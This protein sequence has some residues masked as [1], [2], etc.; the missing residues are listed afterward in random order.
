MH[1]RHAREHQIEAESRFELRV[2]VTDLKVERLQNFRGSLRVLATRRTRLLL[3]SHANAGSDADAYALVPYGMTLA[4]ATDVRFVPISGEIV[5]SRTRHTIV[6]GV[7]LL[8]LAATGGC[9]RAE[10]RQF[11]GDTIRSGWVSAARPSTLR[12]PTAQR[13]F[14]RIASE[15]G[16]FE[17][18][19]SRIAIARGGSPAVR[20][21]AEATLRDRVSVD[22]DLQQ[23]A[24]SVGVQLPSQLNATMQARLAVLATL[25]GSDFDRAYARNVG[26]MA[27]EEALLAFERAA[28]EEGERIER[29]AASQLPTLRKHLEWARQL[30]AEL[31]RTS[32]A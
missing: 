12:P 6:A 21:F 2:N 30:A 22:T 1:P 27:Q 23:L 14:L 9:D 5:R 17:I 11:A 13:D 10:Y 31:D 3:I 32:M 15:A 7:V 25:T 4:Q 24:E 8:V 26:I 29:F 18:E 20:R 16:L 19:A 28:N